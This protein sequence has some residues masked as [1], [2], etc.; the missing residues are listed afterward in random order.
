VAAH[1]GETEIKEKALNSNK[2]KTF[3]ADKTIIKLI[4][5]PEK[6]INIVIR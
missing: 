1:A 5:I 6:L 2:V 3:I 4:Y